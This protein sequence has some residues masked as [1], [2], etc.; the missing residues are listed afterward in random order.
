MRR[1]AF[2]RRPQRGLFTRL[3][4]CDGRGRT[5]TVQGLLLLLQPLLL[6]LRSQAAEQK[7][8]QIGKN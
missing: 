6:L 2:K 5:L 1:K 8:E 7:R 3:L 4:A